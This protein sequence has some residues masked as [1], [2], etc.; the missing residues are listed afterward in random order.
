MD[1]QC[2]CGTWYIIHSNLLYFENLLTFIL[3]K[4][5]SDY[6]ILRDVLRRTYG[7]FPLQGITFFKFVQAIFHALCCLH[8]GRT[9]IKV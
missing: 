4:N 5:C 6:V 9:F 8:S 7:S 2:T 3:H 1:V